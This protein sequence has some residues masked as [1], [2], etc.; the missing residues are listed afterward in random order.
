L[1]WH[2]LLIFDFLLV[3]DFSRVFVFHCLFAFRML[4]GFVDD[5]DCIF[6]VASWLADVTCWSLMGVR[7]ADL[8]QV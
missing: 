1:F 5:L 7:C 4:E 8:A 6:I 3:F 2:V